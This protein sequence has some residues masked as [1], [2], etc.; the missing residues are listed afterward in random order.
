MQNRSR[1]IALFTVLIVT[2]AVGS[3]AL[4]H[5]C[6]TNSDSGGSSESSNLLP[7]EIGTDAL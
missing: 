3:S 5:A 6:G 2:L 4:L 7:S 1:R